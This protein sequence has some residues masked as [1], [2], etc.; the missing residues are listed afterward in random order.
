MT[1]S[2]QRPPIALPAAASGTPPLRGWRRWL[3]WLPPRGSGT[4]KL[5]VWGPVLTVL[6]F[7]CAMATML[8][9]FQREE[10]Q[11][12]RDDLRRDTEWVQQRIRLQFA[13]LEDH[14]GR[15]AREMSTEDPDA[16][17]FKQASDE[18]LREH[19]MLTGVAL[20]AADGRVRYANTRAFSPLRDSFSPGEL[21]PSGISKAA[22]D[23]ARTVQSP[24]YSRP[25][26]AAEDAALIELQAPLQRRG[27]FGGTLVAVISLPQVLRYHLPSDAAPK[28]AY[29]LL[30]SG[31]NVLASTSGSPTAGALL[32][33]EVAATPNGGFL[34]LRGSTFRTSTGLARNAMFWVIVG[35][36]LL[37]IWVLMISWS[38]MR[39]RFRTQQQ[40]MSETN[41][42]RAMENSM[43][44]GMR[45]IDMEGRITYV[46]PAF[47][48]MTG[49]SEQE[50]VG[51]LP[52]FPYWPDE[53]RDELKRVLQATLRDEAPGNGFE[54]HLRRKD[55]SE[56][57]ARMYVSPLIDSKGRQ[58]G[59]MTSVTDI[60]EP[61][62]IREEL[63]QA[64]ERFTAVLE[65]L[66]AAVSVM[67][68]SPSSPDEP[69]LFANRTYRL[70]FGSDASGHRQLA[71]DPPDNAGVGQDS[72]DSVDSFAGLPTDELASTLPLSS[73]TYVRELD[74]WF[75]VRHRYMRWVDG[76]LVQMLIA[77]DV[78]ARRRAE[79]Q[80]RR[81]EE[82]AQITSRL[83]TMG[84]M[85]S[86]LAHELNQPLTA[87]NNYCVGIINRIKSGGMQ[88][89]A[90]DDALTKTA[91][92]AQRAAG[93]IKRIREFVKKS[94]PIRQPCRVEAIVEAALELA[95]IELKKHNVRF[96]R[97][98]QPGV[99]TIYADPIL[100]EQVLVNL[101]KNA[102]EAVAAAGRPYGRR[103]VRLLIEHDDDHVHFTVRDTGP[104][105][106]EGMLERL[107]EPF[108]STKSEGLGIGLNI[109]R[110]II[111]FH[112]GR[113]TAQND[114][115]GGELAGCTF[116]F[117]L[118]LKIAAAKPD[119]IEEN[120]A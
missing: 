53:T 24:A 93:I 32:Q 55:G 87:I 47:C 45:A 29:T 95:D 46:N 2:I 6:L 10:L 66:D 80:S 117:S 52:P 31:G 104:G 76:R 108:F 77:T 37:T 16:G 33:H 57:D 44:T 83:I 48:R 120:T 103:M 26:R 62:R 113:L 75:D 39:R 18:L 23:A 119:L 65:G 100:I 27:Y 5:F 73:E 106:P 107:F 28:Y 115:N 71:G 116:R 85:A 43:S 13:D 84:E 94:E 91:K 63:G 54:V 60:T 97:R 25:Y 90:L 22:F 102:A 112:Q 42:R 12:E 109:C 14:L 89:Q 9:Y 67:A 98:I 35:L 17:V 56:F 82:K 34:F 7:L 15:L 38:Q 3:R 21:L 69:L 88:P 74:K 79:E 99:P 11:R 111:E 110:S 4:E 86:S 51:C 105:L 49:Y 50:L 101:I 58:F 40:L 20:A 1:D 61:K 118:P 92:Q 30:D 81:Q 78:T 64:H 68:I 59:Y 72:V 19:P 96:E 70:W 36:S 41:F 8:W 114:Y